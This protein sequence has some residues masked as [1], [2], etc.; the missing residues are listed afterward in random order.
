MAKNGALELSIH[1]AGR[2]DKSLTTAISTTEQHKQS[3]KEFIKSRDRWTCGYGNTCN[4]HS[5]IT[6]QVY[7]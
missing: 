5:H 6:G 3:F 2:V 7:R 4:R 1:I